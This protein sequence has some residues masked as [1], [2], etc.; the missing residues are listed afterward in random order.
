[1]RAREGPFDVAEQ[2]TLEQ[3]LGQSRALDRNE[4][5][6]LSLTQPVDRFRDKLLAGTALTEQQ[7]VRVTTG[8]ALDESEHLLECQRPTDEL[9]TR[10]HRSRN[11]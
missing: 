1:L 11:V 5:F 8:N 7:H 3:R 10:G 9:R 6:A 4:R 2:L